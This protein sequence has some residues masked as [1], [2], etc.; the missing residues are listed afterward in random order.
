LHALAR[1]SGKAG[2]TFLTVSMKKGSVT[3]GGARGCFAAR[4]TTS[5]CRAPSASSR[6]IAGAV[7]RER[8]PAVSGPRGPL[9]A[10]AGWSC[11]TPKPPAG[12]GSGRRGL[13]GAGSPQGP[14]GSRS[15]IFLAPLTGL[16]AWG[17]R[18]SPQIGRCPSRRHLHRCRAGDLL[19]ELRHLRQDAIGLALDIHGAVARPPEIGPT[20][21]TR[22]L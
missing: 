8:G 21:L 7:S 16:K 10:W 15:M 4:I 6:R 12:P 11:A 20:D 9:I 14:C 1:A 19:S 3:G 5:R 17:W 22:P 13:S 2:R 18:A